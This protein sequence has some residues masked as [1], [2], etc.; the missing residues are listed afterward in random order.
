MSA[1][2]HVENM[3][4]DYIS[5]LTLK[6]LSVKYHFSVPTISRVLDKAG[7]KRRPK[8]R[9]K[10]EKVAEPVL[11]KIAEEVTNKID[12]EFQEVMESTVRDS[13]EILE[14]LS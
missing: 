3:K 10:K 11:V 14:N 2:D 5:G 8:G 12:E 4:T 6:E 1:Y 7:F 9:R 13:R